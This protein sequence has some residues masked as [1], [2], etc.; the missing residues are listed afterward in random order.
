M[1][2][3]CAC[4]RSS[5]GEEAALQAL[6]QAEGYVH[7]L[8]TPASGPPGAGIANA[9]MSRL[10][11]ANENYLWSDWIS[12]DPNAPRDMT[13]PFVRLRLYHTGSGRY[14]SILSGHL[15]AGT[16]EVGP[17][18]PQWS[19][20]FGSRWRPRTSASSSRTTP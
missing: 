8:L 18:P 14:V 13:R 2:T 9:C 1:P 17:V 11:T 16:D 3:C 12:S 20:T 15:K 6:A 19:I 4:R 10:P 7:G 5:E